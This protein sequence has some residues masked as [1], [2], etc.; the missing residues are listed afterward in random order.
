MLNKR[1]CCPKCEEEMKKDCNWN[2]TEW[3][4]SC[5]HCE[6]MENLDGRERK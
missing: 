4:W 2:E 3:F 1:K 5:T 6:Y